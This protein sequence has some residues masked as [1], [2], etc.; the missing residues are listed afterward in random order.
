MIRKGDC[1]WAAKMA[2]GS[3]PVP[4]VVCEAAEGAAAAGGTLNIPGG[5]RPAAMAAAAAALEDV[6]AVVAGTAGTVVAALTGEA[7]VEAA[8]AAL[9]V[10]PPV[11]TWFMSSP[12][13]W[14]TSIYRCFLPKTMSR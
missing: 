1:I 7:T 11:R 5:R 10:V 3:N 8:V 2:L 4:K 14:N 9:V 13:H 6:E 12:E